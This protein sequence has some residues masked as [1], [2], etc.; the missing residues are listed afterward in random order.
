MRT[1]LAVDYDR[2]VENYKSEGWGIYDD[3]AEM[4]R[5]IA[6][7]DAY[8]GNGG[9]IMALSQC[10]HKPIYRQSYM[11]AGSNPDLDRLL[12]D[13]QSGRVPVAVPESGTTEAGV[14]Q[15]IYEYCKK[16]ALE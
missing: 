13:V 2:I 9:S 3:T 8:F 10:V 11:D 12:A 1:A 6:L 5:A 7:S 16:M 15:A 4:N 14:G